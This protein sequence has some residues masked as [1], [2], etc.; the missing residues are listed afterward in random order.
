MKYFFCSIL[1]MN[2]R[3]TAENWKWKTTNNVCKYIYK[4]YFYTSTNTNDLYI[5]CKVYIHAPTFICLSN[6]HCIYVFIYIY[7]FMFGSY[8]WYRMF[9][10]YD[11]VILIHVLMYIMCIF[12][13]GGLYLLH[14]VQS[15]S[16]YLFSFSF[17]K[18]NKIIS[19]FKSVICI[20]YAWFFGVFL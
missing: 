3:I 6:V 1:K 5:K 20:I 19:N 11:Y 2:N 13:T 4:V 9:E 7:L 10:Y 12:F 15:Q 18:V 16:K 17:W 8:R 14:K